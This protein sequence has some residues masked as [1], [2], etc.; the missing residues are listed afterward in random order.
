MNKLL[1]FLNY[2]KWLN[3]G[4]FTFPNGEPIAWTKNQPP[5][6][7]TRTCK[8]CLKKQMA[9]YNPWTNRLIWYNQDK[10][11]KLYEPQTG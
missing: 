10:W 2:H 9:K 5:I 7:P 4:F 1:C 8:H 11:N 3:Y 6:Y